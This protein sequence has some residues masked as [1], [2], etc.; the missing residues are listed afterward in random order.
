M[1]GH[2]QELSQARKD[3]AHD[4]QLEQLNDEMRELRKLIINLLERITRL[5]VKAG[6]FGLIGGSIPGA[7]ALLIWYLQKHPN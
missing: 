1:P 5:E 7:I 3:G 6:I 2:D 4:N